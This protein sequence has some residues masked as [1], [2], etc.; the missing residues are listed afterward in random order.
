MTS[1]RFVHEKTLELNISAEVLDRVRRQY[2]NAYLIGM[3]QERENRS[4]VDSAIQSVRRFL[5]AIQYKAAYRPREPGDYRFSFSAKQLEHLHSLALRF[6]G[7]VSYYL[8]MVNTRDDLRLGSPSFLT[9]TARIRAQDVPAGSHGA[10]IEPPRV[11][12]H[13]Q[14]IEEPLVTAGE[15]LELW[16]Q[17]AAAEDAER[18]G[19]G[20]D[21]G[22][23]IEWLSGLD[24]EPARVAGQALRGL[25]VLAVPDTDEG[26]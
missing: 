6:P 19:I 23:L 5:G 26:P 14:T 3:T 9:R 17:H 4:G 2:P 15:E 21:A 8:P 13:S 20:R 22:E 25:A 24:S 18:T 10:R 7:R 12:I 11:I 1:R 16:L